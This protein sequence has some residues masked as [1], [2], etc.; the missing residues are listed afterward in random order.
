[1]AF[2]APPEDNYKN[3]RRFQV[4]NKYSNSYNR[5]VIYQGEVD[6]CTGERDGRG[7][8]VWPSSYLELGYYKN[9]AYHGQYMQITYYGDK[10]IVTCKDGKQCGKLSIV[11]ADGKLE[12]TVWK[13]GSFEKHEKCEIF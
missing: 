6:A 4:W 7:I 13:D 11:R 2:L 9:D 10:Y 5:T 1:L 8:T 12:T 3:K